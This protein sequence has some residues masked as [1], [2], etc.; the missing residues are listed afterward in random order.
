MRRI[1][2]ALDQIRPAPPPVRP[3]SRRP[4][5]MAD[6]DRPADQPPMYPGLP[7]DQDPGEYELMN[8]T[9]RRLSRI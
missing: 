9:P 3:P 4:S 5:I 8:F 2:E 1:R 6:H 7:T